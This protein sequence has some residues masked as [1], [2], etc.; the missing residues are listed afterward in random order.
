MAYIR[1]YW[2]DL[3]SGGTLVDAKK[4]NE[5][6]E[7]IAQAM[8]GGF[9]IDTELSAESPNPV[10]NAVITQRILQIEEDV[11]ENT[12]GV[13]ALNEDL[14]ALKYDEAGGGKNIYDKSANMRGYWYNKTTG[15]LE[16]FA[17][18]ACSGKMLIKKGNYYISG[19]NQELRMYSWETDGSYMGSE[20]LRTPCSF[21]PSREQYI[22]INYE[23]DTDV[24]T[25]QIE[26][27]DTPTT[28]TPYIKP[29]SRLSELTDNISDAYN[30][31][32]P[33]V[34]KDLCIYNNTV[35]KCILAN[36]GAV[37]TDTTYWTPT[38]LGNEVSALNSSFAVY[39]SKKTTG[40]TYGD[41]QVYYPDKG[42]I[43]I[44]IA[45]SNNN[46]VVFTINNVTNTSCQ[47]IARTSQGEVL[48]NAEV[49]INAFV[50]WG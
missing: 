36:T 39:Q 23:R 6:E 19:I 17:A 1:H 38:N 35:Y 25:I 3:E 46:N 21:E 42:K 37:P 10:Q 28:Y 2:Q 12:E 30:Q 43:P 41:F 29:L 45:N 14:S 7:G 26:E 33:Y 34:A 31:L 20:I 18:T 32:K 47:F 11:S 9:I 48:K 40:G 24:S 4:L 15:E 8:S 16:E 27:G 49:T 5:M 13:S 44:V 50:Y 22:A